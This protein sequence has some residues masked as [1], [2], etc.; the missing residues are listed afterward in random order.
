MA[1]QKSV[2]VRHPVVRTVVIPERAL[3]A[4]ERVL[5]APQRVYNVDSDWIR[6][7]KY[8]GGRL[9][10]RMFTSM[11]DMPVPRELEDEL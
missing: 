5:N 2:P 6:T 10:R 8:K 3:A 7:P 9:R 1:R 11:K 4:M